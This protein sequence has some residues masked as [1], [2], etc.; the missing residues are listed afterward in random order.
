VLGT[1]STIVI[2]GQ[3]LWVLA[4]ARGV[5]LGVPHWGFLAALGTSIV[6]GILG[7]LWGLQLATGDK[8]LPTDGEGAHPA[9]MVV[10][11][12]VPVGLAM[13]E[14]AFSFPH[15]PRATRRDHQ[16]VFPCGGCADALILLDII[17][18]RGSQSFSGSP[19]WDL[20]Q[21]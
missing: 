20:H 5:E 18:S 3:F 7:I 13:S 12:L 16:M 19:E 17:R 2:A 1:I 8:Y 4:R 11:F 9:T 15:P 10:G 14:W 6:G 21:A